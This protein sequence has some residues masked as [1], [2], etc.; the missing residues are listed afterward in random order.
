MI[1]HGTTGFII[2]PG[3]SSAFAEAAIH[4]MEQPS[5]RRQMGE[6]ALHSVDRFSDDLFMKNWLMLLNQLDE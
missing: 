2:P 6:A 3:D 4:L 5:L 1:E